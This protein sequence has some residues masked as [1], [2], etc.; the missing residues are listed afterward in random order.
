MTTS[1]NQIYR[2]IGELTAVVRT[3]GEKIEANENRNVA[4]IEQAN[5]SRA[6][7]HNRL[8]ELFD[9]T[10]RLESATSTVQETVAEMEKVT[11]EVT[12]MRAQAQGAG[13]L[14]RALLAIGGWVISAAVSIAA[15]YTWLTGRPPP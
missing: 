7:V 13:T 2:S 15:F 3:L 4:A 9:R 12:A 6:I 10:T 11:I 5:Q 1:L 14:G 8:D